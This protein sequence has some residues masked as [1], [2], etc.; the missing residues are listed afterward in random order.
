[1]QT[2]FKA[3]VLLEEIDHFTPPEIVQVSNGVQEFRSVSIVRFK[4]IDL[5]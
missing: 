3:F 5:I 1:M 4:I 2:L